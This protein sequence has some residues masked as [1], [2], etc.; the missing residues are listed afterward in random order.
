VQ[1]ALIPPRGLENY[2]LHSTFHLALAIPQC[3][4]NYDYTNAYSDAATRGD[5]IVVDNGAADGGLVSNE[6]LLDAAFMLAA[7]EIVAPDVFYD[8]AATIVKVK[9]FLRKFQ[10]PLVPYKIMAVAQGTSPA[11]I[12]RCIDVY[13][14]LPEIDV[15]GL[16]KHMLTTLNVKAA[17]LDMAKWID[18]C[19]PGRF[20]IH[21]LG[22][23]PVWLKEIVSVAKYAPFVRSVDSA[24]PFNYAL[25]S[26][27]LAMTK[28]ELTRNPEYFDLDWSETASTRH[29]NNNIK[30]FMGWANATSVKETSTCEL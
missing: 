12:R 23:N 4:S 5:Y 17:R 1:A 30:T 10:L 8:K 6:E 16:P 13:A 7:K 18:E 15:V 24:L 27:D 20:Q 22:T 19:F 9:E 26:Q 14:T 2:I 25:A 11:S 3:M 21:M 29:V 28:L